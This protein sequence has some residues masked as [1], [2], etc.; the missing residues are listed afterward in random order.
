MRGV[1]EP[2]V[3]GPHGG[4]SISLSKKNAHP[5]R[6]ELRLPRQGPLLLP[7][8]AAQWLVGLLCRCGPVPLLAATLPACCMHLAIAWSIHAGLQLV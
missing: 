4:P 8:A 5:A 3:G 7:A 1:R 6:T 2:C